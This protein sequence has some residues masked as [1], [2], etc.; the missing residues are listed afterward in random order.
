MTELEREIAAL[1]E[2]VQRLSDELDAYR[3]AMPGWKYSPK[4][5]CLYFLDDAMDRGDEF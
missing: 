3:A 2:Q 1:A 5:R 4:G